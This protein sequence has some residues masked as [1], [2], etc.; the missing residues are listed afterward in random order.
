[1]VDHTTNS[2]PHHASRALKVEGA[3][4]GVGVHGLFSELSILSAVSDHCK[5]ECGNEMNDISTAN[6]CN[7]AQLS[8][9]VNYNYSALL[10]GT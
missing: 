1:L 10:T 7:T 8:N 9:I 4:V 5:K 3:L 6:V 2:A